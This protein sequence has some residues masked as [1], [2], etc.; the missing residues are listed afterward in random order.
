MEIAIVIDMSRTKLNLPLRWPMVL[1]SI[2]WLALG[3]FSFVRAGQTVTLAWDANSESDIA[4]YRLRYGVSSG[5]FTT[6]IDA[7]KNTSAIVL[8]LTP[9][10]TYFFAVTAYNATG[11]ES[12]PSNEISATT[13]QISSALT[14]SGARY[15]AFSY[16]I[17]ASNNPTTYGATG[18]PPGLSVNT[19]TGLIS[20]TPTTTG[21]WNITLSATNADGTA[22]ETLPLTIEKGSISFLAARGDYDGLAMADM[23][24]HP[25]SGSVKIF[26]TAAGKF[27]GAI[28]LAGIRHPFAGNFNANGG[29][30][31]GI[32]KLS[33]RTLP[34]RGSTPLQLGLQLDIGA[35]SAYR[36]TGTLASAGVVVSSIECDQALYTDAK[37]LVAP[38]RAVPPELAG[39]YTFILPAPPANGTAVPKGNGWGRL[40][41]TQNGSVRIAGK[42]A[43]GVAV[44]CSTSLAQD[45]TLPLYSALYRNGG[46]IC[47]KVSLVPDSSSDVTGAVVWFRPALPGRALYPSG[48][49]NGLPLNLLGSH[50]LSPAIAAGPPVSGT[51]VTVLLSGGNLVS[52]LVIPASLTSTGVT[53]LPPLV[54]RGFTFSV[55]PAN[56]IFSGK[57]INPRSAL[58]QTFAGVWLQ[59]QSAAAGF[60]IGTT[61]SGAVTVKPNTN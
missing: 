29:A 40:L 37:N 5:S 60:F 17:V 28:T 58:L 54:L 26:V 48:W 22:T 41:V 56:G 10:V 21:S 24:T 6:T 44:A 35:N 31:F 23:P 18:L 46:A 9:G 13:P 11:L 20:G 52:D 12:L 57:F 25:T 53:P 32:L 30:T 47:G 1:W 36:V 42:L 43:D 27:T 2:L 16:Q 50:Y 3:S 8:D 4:G 14:A 15:S 49:P 55:N 51:A 38:R 59:H 34:R 45:G 61:E 33:T 7:G 39:A 19:T